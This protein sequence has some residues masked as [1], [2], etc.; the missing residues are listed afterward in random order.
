MGFDWGWA[1][2]LSSVKGCFYGR[3]PPHQFM[4]TRFGLVVVALVGDGGVY[5]IFV[6]QFLVLRV[7]WDRQLLVESVLFSN[8]PLWEP[9]V[10]LKSLRLWVGRR[11]IVTSRRSGHPSRTRRVSCARDGRR[12]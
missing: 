6:F 8:D 2:P 11:R 5:H 12:S 9:I 4:T 7:P 3:R 10:L 1:T